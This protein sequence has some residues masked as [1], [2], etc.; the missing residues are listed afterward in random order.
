MFPGRTDVSWPWVMRFQVALNSRNTLAKVNSN[1]RA[2][3]TALAEGGVWEYH[4]GHS[5]RV[6]CTSKAQVSLGLGLAG[7]SS[8]SREHEPKQPGR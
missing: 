7:V 3:V 4:M 1:L 6:H 5:P 2:S 8:T